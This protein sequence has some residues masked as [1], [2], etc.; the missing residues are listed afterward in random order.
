VSVIVIF[1]ASIIQPWYNQTMEVLSLF[2][3]CGGMDLGFEGGFDVLKASVNE[4]IHPDWIEKDHGNGFVRLATTRF[5]TVF[6]N[7]LNEKAKR[8]WVR[9]FS[10]T[11]HHPDEYHVASVVDLVKAAKNGTFKFPAADVVTGGF[12]CLDFSLSGK[13]KGF[14][15]DK[16]HNG[17]K[18]VGETSS[19]E[20][21]GMLYYWMKEVISIVQPS[22]FVAENVGSIKSLP[23]VFAKIFKDFSSIGYSVQEKTLACINYGVPQTRVR[24]IFIGVKDTIKAPTNIHPI[25]THGDVLGSDS[26]LSFFNENK[27][28]IVTAGQA[29]AS[30]QEPD[31]SS[32]LSQKYLSKANFYGK[33]MQG[34]TEVVLTNPGPTIRAEHHGNI[35]FRR[36][37]KEHGGKNLHEIS[38]GLTERRLTVRE[39]ARLQTFPDDFEFV[40]DG[41]PSIKG[42]GP[43][44][45][46]AIGNAVPPLL[47]YH[48]ASRIK[49][50][51]VIG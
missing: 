4:Q 37:T 36:L 21:R 29:F 46:R 47:A 33:H 43:D 39:C 41:D 10:K 50:L 5:K 38:A 35:E 26:S 23:D 8:I 49:E 13:R 30:L 28:D 16:D 22:V 31:E 27:K 19:D 45:Y 32:D 2:S 3:G 9:N 7:D 40:F 1:H 44:A 11:G 17:I 12:P 6:A 14:Q 25:P 24:V 18:L 15:S 48:I 34:Q 42:G 51:G 20:N